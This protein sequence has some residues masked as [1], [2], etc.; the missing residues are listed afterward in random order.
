M[1]E[2]QTPRSQMG[3]LFFALHLYL[4][5]RYLENPQSAGGP[6]Q[7]KSSPT[8]T[9]LV[10]VTTYGTFFTINSPPPCQVLCDKLFLN[11][12]LARGI[13]I[14]QII[15]FELRGVGPLTVHVL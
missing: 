11:K 15:E 9:W 3:R 13:L 12:K 4:A 6:V 14:E 10:G 7:C 5:G 1:S 8:I 2:C